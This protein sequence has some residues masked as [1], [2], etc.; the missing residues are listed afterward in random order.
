MNERGKSDGC[1][2]PAKPANKAVVAAAES[3][4]ERRPAEGNMAGKTRPG[5]RAGTGALSAL[6]RVRELARKDKWCIHFPMCVFAFGP[7]ARAQCVSSARWDL[8]GGPL[9][10]A[11][12]TAITCRPDTDSAVH[13]GLFSHPAGERED[14]KRRKPRGAEYRRGA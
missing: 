2:V 4:E 9:A 13:V 11:V 5:H 3:V 10:R 8:C 12:P 1:V 7:K 6:D 14:P